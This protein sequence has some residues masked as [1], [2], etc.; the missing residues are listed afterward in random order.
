VRRRSF[1]S[2]GGERV[3]AP[4]SKLYQLIEVKCGLLLASRPVLFDSHPAFQFFLFPAHAEN[5]PLK[6]PQSQFLRRWR[7]LTQTSCTT[8]QVSSWP[9][10]ISSCRRCSS[11]A[12][13][14]ARSLPISSQCSIIGR[15]M[16]ASATDLFLPSEEWCTLSQIFQRGCRYQPTKPERPRARCL[17]LTTARARPTASWLSGTDYRTRVRS[18]EHGLTPRLLRCSSWSWRLWFLRAGLSNGLDCGRYA[19]STW[20]HCDSAE[21]D[22]M[23]RA[24][25][26]D[27]V[28]VHWGFA[29]SSVASE[30][31]VWPHLAALFSW[32]CW[33]GLGPRRWSRTVSLSL[34]WA[35]TVWN[36]R[37]RRIVRRDAPGIDA[38]P[39]SQTGAPPWIFVFFLRSKIN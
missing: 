20:L 23:I 25:F 10:L 19:R 39:S 14:F 27:L 36:S 7:S 26:A 15:K 24:N 12:S 32:I 9:R 30:A 21:N 34:W 28:Q 37:Q 22:Q 6:N 1:R 33:R 8:V 13:H 4:F 11:S 18:L 5:P 31:R 16:K 29:E 38:K 2:Q 3:R 17:H 35:G